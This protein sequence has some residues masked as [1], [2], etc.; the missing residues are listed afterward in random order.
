MLQLHRLKQLRDAE[1]IIEIAREEIEPGD[2]SK[3][4]KESSQEDAK[5]KMMIRKTGKRTMKDKDWKVNSKYT[6]KKMC[7][8]LEIVQKEIMNESKPVNIQINW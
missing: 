6:D 3:S 1:T 8:H 5:S 4:S 2:D 7:K